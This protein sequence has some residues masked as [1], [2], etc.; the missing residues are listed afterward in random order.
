MQKNKFIRL[1]MNP[2]FVLAV[3]I[4]FALAAAI[5][6]YLKG[7]PG[8]PYTRYN[9]YII[10]RESFHHLIHNIDLYKNHEP[11]HFD[12]FKYSP[13]FAVAMAPFTFLADLPGLILWDLLNALVLFF[14]L[15]SLPVKNENTK[16]Y[17]LWFILIELMTTMQ[18]SQSN[19]LVAGLMVWGF[20]KFEKR[21]VFLASL[22]I[23]LSTY[24]K[25]YGVLAALI[26]LFYPDKI[27]FVYYSLLWMLM[28]TFIPLLFVS[29]DQLLFLYKSWYNIVINDYSTEHGISVHGILYAWF[30]A[31]PEKSLLLVTGLVLLS[32]PLFRIHRY[33]ELNFRLAYFA[34]LL[35]WMIIF[36]HRAESSTF[37]IAVTGIALWF[38]NS[39]K[40]PVDVTLVVL[41]FLLTSFS[42]TDLFPKYLR[43]HFVL[44]YVLKAL[45]CI[46]I[47][48]K[49]T[50]D[51]IAGKDYR[52][53][54]IPQP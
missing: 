28:L 29:F 1:V 38:F 35:I 37:V 18:N 8:E 41:A 31:E 10:F 12:Y 44:P 49:I 24:I 11:E 32:L 33:K 23:L 43:D 13:A 3:F 14:A 39:E 34:S 26:F 20:N 46:L 51:L 54:K 4:L 50:I 45:P 36:N 53:L 5:G 6:Q 16:I 27:K 52:V 15:K 21:N 17:I 47:W 40:K 22:F 30:H 9:N 19:G 42:P 48:T 2:R 7:K 25:I